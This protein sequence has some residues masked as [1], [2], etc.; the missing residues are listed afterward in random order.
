[1][2]SDKCDYCYNEE[3]DSMI[4]ALTQ[5]EFTLS[6]LRDP[7]EFI[8]PQGMFIYSLNIQHFIFAVEDPSLN[9]IFLLIKRYIIHLRSYKL[10]FVPQVVVNQLLQRICTIDVLIE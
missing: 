9:L 3:K 1:M 6:D 8:Y 4:H 10:S 7:L 5:C 2:Q